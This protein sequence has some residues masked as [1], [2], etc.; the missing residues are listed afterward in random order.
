MYI[1]H[2]YVTLIHVVL[3]H[4]YFAA[5]DIND[6]IICTASLR[7]ANEKT[8]RTW[9]LHV[10]TIPQF[11]VERYTGQKLCTCNIYTSIGLPVHWAPGPL[12]SRSIGRGMRTITARSAGLSHVSTAQCRRQGQDGT[13]LWRYWTLCWSAAIA[14]L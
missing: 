11:L 4:D 3:V 2:V 9:A 1:V 12:G 5:A 10:R 6:K 8:S 14:W 13:G 7:H